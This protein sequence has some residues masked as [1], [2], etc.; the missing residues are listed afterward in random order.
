MAGD[1][2]SAEAEIGIVLTL[3]A[4]LLRGLVAIGLVV[5]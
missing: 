4:A 3:A 2:A 1:C 5:G